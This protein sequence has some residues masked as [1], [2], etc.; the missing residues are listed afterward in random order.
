MSIYVVL[1]SGIPK[2]Q[3]GPHVLLHKV[4]SGRMVHYHIKHRRRGPVDIAKGR[5]GTHGSRAHSWTKQP[6]GNLHR[7]IFHHVI[8]IRTCPKREGYTMLYQHTLKLKFVWQNDHNSMIFHY[9]ISWNWGYTPFFHLTA[10]TASWT[11]W[12]LS[13]LP[14][15]NMS[16]NLMNCCLPQKLLVNVVFMIFCDFIWLYHVLCSFLDDQ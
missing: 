1:I 3:P 7:G 8:S 4:F 12:N 15:C 2:N 16:K 10:Q 14:S 13:L 11:R 5:S 9:L 6:G